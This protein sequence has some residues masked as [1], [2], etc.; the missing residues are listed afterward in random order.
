MSNTIKDK[1]ALAKASISANSSNNTVIQNSE[2]YNPIFCDN[3]SEMMQVM[4]DM[5]RYD[6]I[7]QR[8]D[9]VLSDAQQT[10]PLYPLFSATYDSKLKRLI[11]TPETDDALKKYPKSLKGSVV[12]DYNKY[13]YMDKSETPG[14][15]AYRTQ[16]K[17]ECKMT[18][19]KEYLGDREDPFPVIQFNEDL[20]SVIEPPEFPPAMS[21]KII[22]GNVTLPISIRRKPCLNYGEMIFGT[23]N[24][25]I[26]FTMDFVSYENTNKVDLKLTKFS[27]SSLDIQLKREELLNAIFTTK[28]ISITGDDD[29]E[30][31]S[32]KASQSDVAIDILTNSFYMIQYIKDLISIEEK[33]NCKFDTEIGNVLFEDYITARTLALSLADKWH[34]ISMTFDDTLRCDYDHIAEK[35][36][37]GV[38]EP[39]P[40]SVEIKNLYIQLQG[41]NF[42]IENNKISYIDAKI[43]NIDSVIK[44]YK[45]KRKNILITFKPYNGKSN[46]YK[47]CKFEGVKAE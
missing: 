1:F 35:I 47:Y 8:I 10:H 20:I 43:N 25:D 31:V 9:K 19:Y 38:A 18:S 30:L 28:V 46:F 7:Q 22:S 27:N 40:Y 32:Y 37:E 45:K 23:T 16:T 11:S 41:Q 24:D 3:T 29:V 12:V 6:L 33:T 5:G 13:P 39:L 44:S 26:G 34:G 17:V 21:A 15:Y 2:L 4:A 42:V 36:I 14:D